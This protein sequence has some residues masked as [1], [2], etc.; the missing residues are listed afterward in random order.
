MV[1]VMVVN[2]VENVAVVDVLVELELQEV[3]PVACVCVIVRVDPG[4]WETC[5][6]VTVATPVMAV[7]DR[8]VVL[9]TVETLVSVV[10]VIPGTVLVNVDTL[11]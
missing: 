8:V 6:T 9:V 10:P 3:Q 4:C 7:L 1:V 5:V 11:V 2:A